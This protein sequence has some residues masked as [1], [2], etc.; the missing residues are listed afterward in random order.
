MNDS[1]I[2]ILSARLAQVQRLRD[3]ILPVFN[4]LK[5]YY[6]HDVSKLTAS[7]IHVNDE[8]TRG[9]IQQLLELLR[10]PQQL[11]DE[12]QDLHRILTQPDE[13][14]TQHGLDG[15]TGLWRTQ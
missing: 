12:I 14:T 8:V 2:A 4:L 1:D 5:T 9:R 11:D 3:G 7:L 13:T 6:E 15:L 10:L